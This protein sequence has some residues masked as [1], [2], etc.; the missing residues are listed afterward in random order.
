MEGSD[1]RIAK[2]YS[3]DVRKINDAKDTPFF[4]ASIKLLLSSFPLRPLRQTQ[5]DA[6][7]LSSQVW[8]ARGKSI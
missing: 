2:E 3:L 6:S 7:I 4:C 5:I 1:I 8:V